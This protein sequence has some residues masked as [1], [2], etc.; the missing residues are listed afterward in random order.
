MFCNKKDETH[1]DFEFTKEAV[2]IADSH[3]FRLHG[4][5]IDKRWLGGPR[6]SQSEV[7]K[8]PLF[9]LLLVGLMI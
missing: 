9:F 6:S 3:L 7:M 1:L 4:E 2:E 5:A 8:L